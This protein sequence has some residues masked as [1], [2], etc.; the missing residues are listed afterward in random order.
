MLELKRKLELNNVISNKKINKE[1]EEHEELID[2]IINNFNCISID[3]N[4]KE[5]E[6]IDLTNLDTKIFSNSNTE[7]SI[8]NN[9][10]FLLNDI[11]ICPICNQQQYRLYLYY[12]R[13]CNHCTNKYYILD[14]NYNRMIFGNLGI[15]GGIQSFTFINGEKVVSKPS[16][17]NPLVYNCNI[18]G[19]K[20]IA[21]ENIYG[22]IIIQ[23]I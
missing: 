23:K 7:K 4:K 1:K 15:A 18:L 22:G 17:N 10:K 16:I 2:L 12:N 9:Q 5:E 8:L 21:R 14:D 11:E 19:I 13:V 6:I 3:T 20:C